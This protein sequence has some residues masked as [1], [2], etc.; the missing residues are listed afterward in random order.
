MSACTC[1]KACRAAQRAISGSKIRPGR[2]AGYV[3]TSVHGCVCLRTHSLS[4]SVRVCVSHSELK[5]LRLS[6]LCLKTNEYK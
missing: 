5:L 2:P 3:K 4:G 6:Q 1:V